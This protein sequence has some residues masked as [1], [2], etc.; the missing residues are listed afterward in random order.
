MSLDDAVNTFVKREVVNSRI[1]NTSRG[2]VYKALSEPDLL[3]QWWGPNGFKN[4]FHVFQFQ[5]GGLWEYT[6]HGPDGVAHKNKSEFLEIDPE[7]RI[8]LRHL[9]PDHVFL[10]EITLQAI[11]NDTKINWRMIFESI[12]EYEEAKQF[13]KEMNEQNLDRLEALVNEMN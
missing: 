6:M 10:L 11:G 5:K 1:I 12:E 13:V 3:K 8:L 2:K 7:T 9:E 4:T